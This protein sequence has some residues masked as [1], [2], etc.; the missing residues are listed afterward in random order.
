MQPMP[1]RWTTDFKGPAVA[2]WQM[3]GSVGLY[4][5]GGAPVARGKR[6]QDA[7][8]VSC[9]SR[10]L[11]LPA[12]SNRV[13]SH[14]Q[15]QALQSFSITAESTLTPAA[16]ALHCPLQSSQHHQTPG[17][18]LSRVSVMPAGAV[19]DGRGL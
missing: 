8:M 17:Q 13:R 5:Y 2:P 11:C 3:D 16:L 12:L 6:R 9:C 4:S 7:D 19:G 10:G 18:A 1:A 15:N 14:T